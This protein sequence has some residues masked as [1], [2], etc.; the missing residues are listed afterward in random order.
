[1]DSAEPKLVLQ[2]VSDTARLKGGRDRLFESEGTGDVWYHRR[3]RGRRYGL[4]LST[5]VPLQPEHNGAQPASE[6]PACEQPVRSWRS[7][8]RSWQ[9]AAVRYRIKSVTA[10]SDAVL[11]VCTGAFLVWVLLWQYSRF[12]AGEFAYH[13]LTIIS[14]FFSNAWNHGRPF[15]VTNASETHFKTHITPT[16]IFLVPL[17]GF[18]RSQFALVAIMAGL[19]C[20]GLLLATRHQLHS[21]RRL[22]VPALWSWLLALSFFVASALNRYTLRCLD[23]AHFEP[24]FILTAFLLLGAISRGSSYGTLVAF[25]ALAL[26]V[27]QD[28]GLFLF[29]LLLSCLVA[30]RAWGRAHPVQILVCAGLCIPYV[31][32]ASKVLLPWFGND[33]N[34][35]YWHEWGA[36]WPEVFRAWLHNSDRVRS[37]VELSEFPAFNAELLYTQ[38]LNPLAWCANQ[39]PGILFY[40]ADSSDKPRLL[41]Y[42]SAFLLPGLLLCVAF[43]QLHLATLVVRFV[44][45]KLARHAAL[46]LV[47]AV[48]AYV[49]I[50]AG[51][52]LPR[53]S[54][55]VLQ[56]GE[57]R[58]HDVFAAAPLKQ[59]LRC[60]AVRSVAADFKTIVYIP[61]RLDKYLLEK[62]DRSDVV[63]I[64]RALN[65]HTP[66]FVKPSRLI[67]NLT[68]DGKYQHAGSF[69]S[70]ELY[71]RSGLDC[72]TQTTSSA[73]P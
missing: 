70:Y 7:V 14:D 13:D 10:R 37:A 52:L 3:T 66:F 58:R 64:D 55:N 30:P 50:N 9:K 11:A 21:L 5:T 6:Q 44:R 19:V 23:S 71:V 46:A 29:F 40:T 32:L 34:T 36:T 65:K 18:F 53:D 72:P 41:F 68:R 45:N 25:T 4:R 33:G 35:R 8:A 69:E 63:V 48:F 59:L 49:A 62:A 38:V 57:L 31:V 2:T 47:T 20:G 15:W 16:L 12:V 24:V 1:M 39:L 60:S 67:Q 43:S 22:G 51:F 26:G 54:E 73:A 56:I 61:L 17:Y 28:A 27:R 42:N